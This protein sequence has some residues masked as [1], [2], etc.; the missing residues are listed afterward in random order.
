MCSTTSVAI[1]MT[2]ILFTNRCSKKKQATTVMGNL[3]YV[4]VCASTAKTFNQAFSSRI[5]TFI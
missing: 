5:G 1:A 3:Y 2:I 4:T